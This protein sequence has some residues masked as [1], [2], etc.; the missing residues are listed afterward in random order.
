MRDPFVELGIGIIGQCI[1]DWRLESKAYNHKISR[2]SEIRKISHFLKSDFANIICSQIDL[3]P[4]I[5]LQNLRKES[6]KNWL[7]F[8][9]ERKRD[10]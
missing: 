5:L 8:E 3:D 2:S 9:K 6:T 7:E 4:K 10:G 1:R